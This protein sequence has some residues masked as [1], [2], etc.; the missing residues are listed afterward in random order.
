MR[1]LIVAATTAFGLSPGASGQTW[2]WQ[3][4]VSDPVV[5]PGEQVTVT[6]TAFMEADAPFVAMSSTWMDATSV[7]GARIGH[8]TGYT[9]LDHFGDLTG[10][11]ATWWLGG[12]TIENLCAGQITIFGPFSTENPVDLFEFCW[13]GD[14]PGEVEYTT[15]TDF[16]YMWIGEDKESAEQ[17]EAKLVHEIDFGW[18]VVACEAD[19]NADGSLDILDFISFQLAWQAEEPIADCDAN[20]A[21]DVL[22]FVC[23]QQAFQRG[24]D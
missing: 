9:I 18:T 4:E 21:F 16:A 12:D 1:S 23:Y 19:V 2:T 14:A 11:C 17:I 20:E 10:E 13:V 6:L 3:V 8:P 5:E 24:C 7:E 15:T 22:D